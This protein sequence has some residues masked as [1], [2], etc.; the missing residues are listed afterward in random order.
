MPIRA[1]SGELDSP[2][3]VTL[4][5]GTLVERVHDRRYGGSGFNPC[6]GAPTRF[7][8]IRDA[9]GHCVPSLYA[10]GTLE[11][12]IYETIFHDVPVQA[13]PG[14]NSGAD[15]GTV[16]KTLV[17]GRAHSRL[18]VLRDLHLASLRG[19]DLRRWGI[20]RNSL[21]AAAPG[22]YAETARWA[23]AI[24]RRFPEVEGLAWTSNRC[25]PDTAYLF[26][27]DRVAEA[28]FRIDRV[29]DGRNDAAFLSDV[30]QAGLK[31]GIF[32]TV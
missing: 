3:I 10:A 14:A 20:D 15:P 29:R 11:A 23:C 31:G 9:E 4:G 24:H 13:D 22:L 16:P 30:R 19:P 28:D 2:N 17:Q 12:A 7:A 21:I 8:P 5:A 26:F 27:G 25:D 32:I 6:K 1:P 18:N